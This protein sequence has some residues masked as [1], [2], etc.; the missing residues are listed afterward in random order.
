M[1]NT[2]TIKE[3]QTELPAMVRRAEKGGIAT[4]TRHQK[5]V[6]YVVSAA[7]M[8]ALV[9][10]MELLANPRAMKALR[11]AKAGRTRYTPLGQL[12]D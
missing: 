11:D 4:I 2:Y 10:T 1:E 9:E 12:A 7:R 6:A 8:G 5:T 3:A